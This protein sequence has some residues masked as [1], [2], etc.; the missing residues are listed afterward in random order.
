[1]SKN[2]DI[3]DDGKFIQNAHH[4]RCRFFIFH[5]DHNILTTLSLTSRRFQSQQSPVAIYEYFCMVLFCLQ[6]FDTVGWA[7][8][9]ASSLQKNESDGGGGH[10]LVRMERH[11]AGWSVCLPL[12]NFPCVIT[13]RSSLLATDRLGGPG[14]GP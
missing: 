7:A 5:S 12:Q 4:T 10:W 3:D 13:S 2:R 14:K 8:G 9:R 6:C 11:P 1:M